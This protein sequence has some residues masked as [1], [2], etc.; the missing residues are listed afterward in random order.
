MSTQKRISFLI[1][2][3]AILG[4]VAVSSTLK[5][6]RATERNIY[7]P[8]EQTYID[9]HYLA[10]FVSLYH[11]N[12]RKAIEEFRKVIEVAK[13]PRFY[14]EYV[15]LLMYAGKLKEA[16]T[17]LKKAM[18]LF[19]KNR[20]IYN[21]YVD[22][23]LFEGKASKAIKFIE[24]HIDIFGKSVDTYR[25]LGIL[26]YRS[27]KPKKAVLY[28]KKAIEM[29][30]H[31]KRTYV[32]MAKCLSELKNYKKAESYLKKALQINPTSINLKL[33]LA[34]IYEKEHKYRKAIE[35]YKTIHMRNGM[36][37]AAI[38]NDYYLSGDLKK[39]L[40]YFKK[41]Y[42]ADNSLS[43]AEKA[44]YLF[45]KLKRYK[46]AEEFMEKYHQSANTNRIKYLYGLIQMNLGHYKKAYELF[47]SVTPRSNLYKDAIYNAAICLVHMGKKEK[48][49]KLIQSIK[50][51]NDDIFIMMATLYLK[52]HEYKKAIE[53]VQRNLDNFKDKA[54]A[55]FFMADIYYQKL[56]NR[57]KCIEYL[58]KALSI[59]P[60]NAEVLNYLGYLYIDEKI[61]IPEGIK[62]VEKALKIQPNN[63]YFLDSLGWGYY[64][65]GKYSKALTLLKKA[66]ENMKNRTDDAVI[67]I[68][69]AKTY[70]KLNDR[71]KAIST[72][73]ET[74]KLHPENREAKKLL[75]SLK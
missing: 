21:T 6:S 54:R 71:K 73:Q 45:L 9:Y 75:N 36:L 47:K 50:N 7:T 30:D 63:P 10:A 42:I 3:L 14:R 13:D 8:Q 35:V 40:E 25:K 38:A 18:K 61:N 51:K 72:L 22:I 43:S 53:T 44:L 17:T 11:G 16:E 58:K 52:M 37:F 27:F 33:M 19:P 34:S 4:M 57:K 65:E 39:A 24:K 55:Y 12:T 70:L 60:E 20:E 49:L 48:A 64:R 1:V 41:A 46:E 56:K 66:I 31:S 29:G 2:A 23:L 5:N 68:H 74:L 69:I 28:F 62:L 59:D 26:Y 15:N 32:Y 67:R